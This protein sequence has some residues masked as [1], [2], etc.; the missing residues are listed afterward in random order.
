MQRRRV[1]VWLLGLL[2]VA[3]GVACTSAAAGHKPTAVPT[4]LAAHTV[5]LRTLSEEL[6]AQ[7]RF[8]ESQQPVFT[9]IP[10][11]CGCGHTLGHRSLR[12]CFIQAPG[13][14]DAHAAGC[15]VCQVEARDVQRMLASGMDVAAI[16]AEIRTRYT[17]VGTPT[18]TQ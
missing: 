8:V 10:C 18:D 3:L 7:Y 9:H 16:R 11:Y 2:L 4:A 12:D 14:Y 6:A 5:D 17:K 1:A 15:G 13:G